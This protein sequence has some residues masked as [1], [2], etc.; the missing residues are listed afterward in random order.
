MDTNNMWSLTINTR[1]QRE[2]STICIQGSHMCWK[3]Y[4]WDNRAWTFTLAFSPGGGGLKLATHC[5]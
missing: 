2:I 5:N 3:T 1:E 4:S